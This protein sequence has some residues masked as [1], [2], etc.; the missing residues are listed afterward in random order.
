MKTTNSPP[1]RPAQIIEEA[2][3]IVIEEGAG[4]LSLRSLAKRIGIKLASLQYY[5]PTKA[6]LVDLLVSDAIAQYREALKG[7]VE[8]RSGHPEAVLE[9]AVRWLVAE[10]PGFDDLARFEVQFWALAFI[11]AEAG[12]ALED[13]LALYRSFLSDLILAANPSL[14]LQSA[15]RRA[16]AIASMIEGSILFTGLRPSK[17]ADLRGVEAEIIEASMLIAMRPSSEAIADGRKN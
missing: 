10:M 4:A 15:Q 1:D 2:R 6:A 13:Y 8:D 12:Q 11:D 17:R 7:F 14:P 9:Q 3:R 5:V 16:A